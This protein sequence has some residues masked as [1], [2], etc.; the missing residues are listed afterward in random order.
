[1]AFHDHGRIYHIGIIDGD[2]VIERA[3][4]SV[5][6]GKIFL[7]LF[8]GGDKHLFGKLEKL[9][10]KAAEHGKRRLDEKHYFLQEL[11]IGIRYAAR[12][13]WQAREASR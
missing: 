9:F 11:V 4:C 8:H 10:F 5:K 2:K 6:H 12:L 7:V 13:F 1:M 3:A